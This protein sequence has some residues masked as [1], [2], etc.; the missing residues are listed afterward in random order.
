MG[1]M[2]A[3][4][5]AAAGFEPNT[6]LTTTPT[7]HASAMSHPDVVAQ[8]TFTHL[9]FT[10]LENVFDQDGGWR[11][12]SLEGKAYDSWFSVTVRVDA[13]LTLSS[14]DFYVDTDLQIDASTLLAR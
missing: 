4:E 7:I 2:P 1:Q 5:N 13:S 8:Q 3:S 14:L 10:K 12:C 11:T 9:T 6:L